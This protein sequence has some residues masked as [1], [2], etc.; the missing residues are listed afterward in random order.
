MYRHSDAL[1]HNVEHTMLVTLAG[2]DISRGRALHAHMP[3]EDYAHLIIACVTHDIGYLRGIPER[4]GD[5]VIDNDLILVWGAQK[6]IIT[7]AD[8]LGRL[9]RD[10]ATVDGGQSTPAA[11]ESLNSAAI[12]AFA[13]LRHTTLCNASQR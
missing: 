13:P 8:L 10:I 6:R 9:L 3:P 1:Y 4:P 2:H 12:C 7:G 5:D 11:N